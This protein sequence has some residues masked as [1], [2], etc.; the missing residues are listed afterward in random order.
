MRRSKKFIIIAV[1]AALVVVGS[2]AG[3]AL[4]QTGNQTGSGNVTQPKT[5]LAR[6]AETLSI[7]QTKL[8]DAFAQ[9]QSEM[10]T[11]ALQNRLQSLV[12]QGKITQPQADDYLNWWEAKP[13]VPAGFGF[14]GRG[15]LRGWGGLGLCPPGNWTMPQK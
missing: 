14:K 10:R 8:E 7:N 2:I 5:L 15:G 6:V 4:A 9:A 12:S 13:D 11:E 1:V 3:V